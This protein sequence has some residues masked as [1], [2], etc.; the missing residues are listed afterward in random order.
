MQE[1]KRRTDM[2]Y[3][4]QFES[5]ADSGSS[6]LPTDLGG[7]APMLSDL[8]ASDATLGK[9]VHIQ[10][11][12]PRA[13]IATP[14]SLA[15]TMYVVMEGTVNLVCSSDR[16]RRL[17]VATLGAGSIFG[18]GPLEEPAISNVVAEAADEVTVWSMPASESR[19]LMVQYPILTWALM[20]TYGQRLA[21]VEDNLEDI[22]YRKLP[23]RLANLVWNLADAAGVVE[24]LSHQAL[25]DYLGTYRETVSAVLRDFKQA[26]VLNLGYRRIQIRDRETLAD[27]AGIWDY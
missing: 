7:L 1:T 4:D 26:G 2:L 12:S 18:Q 6:A 8:K 22:A 5:A 20:Q 23:E 17:I 21:Q 11:F 13:T 10:R 15:K 24:G 14:T 16:R 9:M 25:A 3:Q 27:M 19:T